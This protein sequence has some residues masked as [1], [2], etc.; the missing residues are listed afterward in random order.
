MYWVKSR[1]NPDDEMAT[2]YV[3]GN[4]WPSCIEADTDNGWAIGSCDTKYSG[5]TKK[6]SPQILNSSYY[7]R[8]E[9]KIEIRFE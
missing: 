4:P 5:L 2:V 7:F 1:F 8:R 3:N 9:G 6:F